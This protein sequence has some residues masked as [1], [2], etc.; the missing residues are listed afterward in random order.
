MRL[1]DGRIFERFSQPQ[2]RENKI[3][4]RVWSFLDVTERIKSGEALNQERELLRLLESNTSDLIYFKDLQGRFIRVNE[5]LANM[6]K[7]SV[8]DMVGKTDADLFSGEFAGQTLSEE[9]EIIRTGVSKV[10]YEERGS[11]KDGRITW[12]SSSKGCLRDANGRIIGIYGVSR[13]I[14]KQKEAELALRE[15]ARRLQT[16]FDLAPDFIFVKDTESRYLAVNHALAK[17]YRRQPAEMIG[18]TDADYVPAPMAARFRQSEVEVLGSPAPR[19]YEDTLEFPDGQTRTVVTNMVAFHNDDGKVGG[20]IGVGHDMTAQRQT[21]S[22]VRLQSL[23][24]NTADNAVMITNPQGQIEWANPAFSRNTG[25]SLAE[26]LGKNP[27]ELLRSGQHRPEFYRQMWQTIL[28]GQAWH[29]ELTNRRKDGSLFEEEMT[30]TPLRDEAGRITHFIA[31]KQDVTERRRTFEKLRQ[32]DTRAQFFMNRLPL[33]FIAWNQDFQVTEWNSAAE[34][35]FGWTAAEALGR[36]AFELIVP[37]DVQPLVMKVWQEVVGSGN[38][39]SHSVNENVTKDGRRLTCEWRNLPLRDT[40]G[41]I[42]GCLSVVDDVT[43]RRQAED[44]ISRERARFKFIFESVP[45]G[46]SLYVTRP[47]GTTVHTVNAAHLRNSGLTEEQNR[48][49]NVHRRITHPEDLVRQEQLMEQVKAGKTWHFTM[50]KRFVHADGK[51]VWVDFFY[52]REVFPDGTLQEMVATVDI[53]DRKRLEEQFRQSQKMEAIG[54]LSGGIAHDF[55]NILTVI[56]GNAALLQN[57]DLEP[58]ETRDCSHQIARAAERA[59]ALTRQLLMFARKQQMQPVNL[60]LNE[61]VAQMT[62][63]LQRILGEDV[64]LRTEYAPALP[65][66]RA[67]AGMIEQILLNLAVN[68]RDAMAGGGKLTLRT[69]ADKRRQDTGAEEN[70]ACLQVVD[71]GCGIAPDILPRIFEPFFTTKEVGKG[72]GLG[73]ATVYG[74]VQQHHGEISVQSEIGKGTTFTL[75]FPALAETDAIRATAAAKPVLPWGTETILLVEDE[76]PL[77][78]FVGELLRRCGYTVLEAG[79]GPAAL[80]VWEANREK[81]ALLFTDVIMPEDM[82]GLELAQRLL[83]DKPGLK[84]VYTSGYTGNLEGRPTA[85]VEGGNFIRKPYKPEALASFIRNSLDGKISGT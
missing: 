11:W 84:V 8:A 51:I 60:D 61:S 50:E 23:A 74:I 43:D 39:S 15:N 58:T 36:H 14:T 16:V 44:K 68:A 28:A 49:P 3:I 69:G 20:L 76:L 63:M 33:G 37:T 45:I 29:G 67:D 75:R 25:Y 1:K 13:D 71:S 10:G 66:I 42:T 54:Q 56:Q 21:E 53:T 81:I 62:K 46:I 26:C 80:K 65:L 12:V 9:R 79:S 6:A 17:L 73:L 78:V 18:H 22:F 30:I 59:A 70:L 72:T 48:Q 57:L 82:S 19:T 24:L 55:N 2:R 7:L 85:L 31:I 5:A 64:T 27:R 41:Q 34:K 35:I 77:R 40:Q 47:E 83:A 32:A 52:Q 4:G 38:L